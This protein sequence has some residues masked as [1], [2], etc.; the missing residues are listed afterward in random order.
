MF[1]WEF[2]ISGVK[3]VQSSFITTRRTKNTLLKQ[4]NRI[5]MLFMGTIRESQDLSFAKLQKG[6]ASSCPI[7][8]P[9]DCPK[10]LK[11]GSIESALHMSAKSGFVHN[12]IK[13]RHIRR[14]SVQNKKGILK[15]A[16]EPENIILLVDL[17]EVIRK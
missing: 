6:S 1:A 17:G 2:P 15:R 9:S 5:V 10:R 12:D 11:D 8:T 4:K 16:Q 14:F 13:W 7:C 3:H